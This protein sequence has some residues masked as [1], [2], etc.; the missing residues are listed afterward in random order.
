MSGPCTAS[1]SEPIDQPRIY[2]SNSTWW[3]LRVINVFQFLIS[4][5]LPTPPPYLMILR[6]AAP[7]VF[8]LY[9]EAIFY[10]LY[11]NTLRYEATETKTKIPFRVWN[12]HG[13]VNKSSLT[14]QLRTAIGPFDTS[15]HP[16]LQSY[17]SSQQSPGLPEE[18]YSNEAKNKLEI[19]FQIFHFLCN[20][21]PLVRGEREICG[22]NQSVNMICSDDCLV[23]CPSL[24]PSPP[25]QASHQVTPSPDT[26][27][28]LST[29]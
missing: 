22:G 3:E 14:R 7:R 17:K 16:D 6:Q 8:C 15:W 24:P 10:I 1:S 29:F 27:S 25:E 9:E 20:D 5:V 21:S 12:S 28:S 4:A 13:A 11:F 23:R 26:W 19:N 2:F 18:V